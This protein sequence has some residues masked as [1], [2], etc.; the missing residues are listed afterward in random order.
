MKREVLLCWRITESSG[1]DEES[2][3]GRDNE[4]EDVAQL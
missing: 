3:A 1:K 2:A 4:Q